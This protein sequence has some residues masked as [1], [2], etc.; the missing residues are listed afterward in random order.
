M[1]TIEE[2][3]N[4]AGVSVATVSRALNNSSKVKPETAR[5]VLEAV[6]ALN[7]VPNPSARNL[8]KQENRVI[9]VLASNFSNPFYS[10]V[11]TGIGDAA[12]E[13]EYSVLF[14]STK[15]KKKREEH[16]LEML[17]NRQADGAIL[18]GVKKDA[19]WLAEY[20]AQFPI[21]QC[22][23]YVPELDCPS[24]SIDN[25]TAALVTVR[26]LQQ[27]GHRRIAMIGANNSYISTQLRREGYLDAM[28][29]AG[30][31][32]PV[33]LYA[34]ADEHYSFA[35]GQSATKK[36]LLQ[37]PRPT[38]VFCVSDILA[39]S[40]ISVAQDLGLTVP[41]DL[42]V[43]GFDDVDYTTVFHPYLTSVAQPGYE[44]GEQSLK[45]LLEMLAGENSQRAGR[46]FIPHWFV[47]RESTAQ[48]M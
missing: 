28:G 43:T 1:A 15:G 12:C 27:L 24:I 3:A 5:R 26:Y 22:C 34:E 18:L 41:D 44:L 32:A 31:E 23:E 42:T 36:L 10:E 7:Y 2:V 14:C 48:N 39:L 30:L 21:V 38:A 17:P 20:T 6:R 8:R 25:Y 46:V 11:L 35:S 19:T 45:L 4:H 40:V 47:E 9:L 13:R 16:F 33:C 37:N 29:A